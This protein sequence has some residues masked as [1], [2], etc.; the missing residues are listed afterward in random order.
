MD[1]NAGKRFQFEV[2]SQS[3]STVKGC[4][5]DSKGTVVQ[6]NHKTYRYVVQFENFAMD[7]SLKLV[8]FLFRMCANSEED[9]SIWVES[10]QDSIKE[11]QF[12]DIISAKKAALRRK[13]LKPVHHDIPNNAELTIVQ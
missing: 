13:S 8:I 12:Y 9:R 2:Y 7:I 4:K 10:I 6:G 3:N 11:H 1:D 5:T